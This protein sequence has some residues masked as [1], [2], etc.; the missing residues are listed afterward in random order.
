M[1]IIES[2]KA[3]SGLARFASL[4]YRS[5]SGELARFTIQLGFS[6]KNAVEQSLLE[7]E[8]ERPKFFGDEATAA[9]ELI[10]SFKSTLAGTQTNY[11]KADI[12]KPFIDEQGLPVQGVKVSDSDGSVK[13]F[14]LVASKVQLERPTAERVIRNSSSLTLAKNKL[15]KGLAVGKFREFSLDSIEAMRSGRSLSFGS[16]AFDS[17][18]NK[19]IV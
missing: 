7:L 16:R 6:Y 14:G 17:K 1:K 19:E 10:E 9:D 18:E 12:Y 5:N 15:R 3:N 8:I 2:I 4:T 13:V 11:T